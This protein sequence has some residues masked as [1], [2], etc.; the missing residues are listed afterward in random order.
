MNQTG[1]GWPD[2]AYGSPS[3]LETRPAP[4]IPSPREGRAGRG[5][6]RG[7]R[8][9]SKDN[10]SNVL[11][12]EPLS[13]TLSP[14]SGEREWPAPSPLLGCA[15]LVRLSPGIDRDHLDR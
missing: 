2:S 11:R 13:P 10:T 8:T 7:V 9:C 3:A 4:P 12:D 5:L 14:P 15:R 1:A 6:G